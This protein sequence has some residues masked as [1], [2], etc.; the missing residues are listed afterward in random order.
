MSASD[1]LHI[2]AI[3]FGITSCILSSSA[4]FGLY[5]Q[6]KRMKIQS[7][8]DR[9]RYAVYEELIEK[10]KKENKDLKTSLAYYEKIIEGKVVD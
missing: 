8:I 5:S 2:V 7:R 9:D 6:S 10:V 3:A 4:L 1:I